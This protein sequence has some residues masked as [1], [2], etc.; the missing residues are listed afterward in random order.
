MPGPVRAAKAQNLLG[1]CV[2]LDTKVRRIAAEARQ[3]AWFVHEPSQ[4][5]KRFCR[6]PGKPPPITAPSREPPLYPARGGMALA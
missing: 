5:K 4:P 3:P 2:Q 1:R 6:P